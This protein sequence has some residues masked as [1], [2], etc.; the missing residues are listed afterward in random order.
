MKFEN[1]KGTEEIK[2]SN[3]IT[4]IKKMVIGA[5]IVGNINPSVIANNENFLKDKK[6][7]KK[8][9]T[10]DFESNV[11]KSENKIEFSATN[12]FEPDS[13]VISPEAI[14]DICLNFQKLL[15]QI[16][17]D[18]YNKILE[19]GI[20][21]A[22]GADPNLSVRFK[23]NEE[24]ATA[25][26]KS[27]IAFLEDYLQKADFPNLD[28]EKVKNLKDKIQFIIEIPVSQKVENP[29][30]G[31]IYPEDLGY[32]KQDLNK[33]NQNQIEEIYKSC[34]VVTV[35]LGLEI[36]KDKT[37]RTSA[38][39]FINP[40]QEK[41]ILE[42]S[43]VSNVEKKVNWDAKIIKLDVDGTQSMDNKDKDK[44]VSW[45]LA[46]K[47]IA[48][49]PTLK[50]K[51][52]NLSFFTD[53]R[54]ETESFAGIDEVINR[55]E[56]EEYNSKQKGGIEHA[57]DASLKSLEEMPDNAEKKIYK[58]FT[59]ELLQ[60]VS[61]NKVKKLQELS[62]RKNVD[63]KLYFIN[64]DKVMMEISLREIEEL[65]QYKIMKDLKDR[66]KSVLGYKR[67]KNNDLEKEKRNEANKKLDEFIDS[68][69]NWNFDGVVSSPLIL[70]YF[71]KNR[72]AE[73]DI[74]GYLFNKNL[75]N[76]NLD[77]RGWEVDI[78]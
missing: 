78:K 8:E 10:K 40:M 1:F 53:V 59:D 2:K 16:N 7:E 77:G 65:I 51:D 4:K 73:K 32:T 23:N 47:K 67:D 41:G 25:R 76:V 9:N 43:F 12:F 48:N 66:F 22:P 14:N 18:N 11:V 56:N 34:R 24:L 64:N 61:I 45:S 5:L 70:E 37:Y 35:S 55:I 46:V 58:I 72:E 74:K 49:D 52:I 75:P 36:E 21:V 68:L 38:G 26:A 44:A 29:Q 6:S 62:Q 17:E 50:N 19:Y 15:D 31:V 33:M 63:A 42:S 27:L 20:I 30:I 60:D 54:T 39:D 28:A 57:L 13:D 3:I 69:K 71:P